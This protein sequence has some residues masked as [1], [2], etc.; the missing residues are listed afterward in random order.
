MVASEKITAV[1]TELVNTYR[2]TY[3]QAMLTELPDMTFRQFVYLD[4]IVRMD[5]PTYGE[6]AAKFKVTKPAVTA[7]VNKLIGLGYL[8]RLQSQTDLRIHHLVVCEKARAILEVENSTAMGWV[9]AMKECL[10]EEEAEQ[11][12]AIAAKIIAS[13]KNKRQ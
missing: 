7:I 11:F 5:N 12:V 2:E 6:V 3:R 10:T 4:A 13:K 1:L 8:E 9:T